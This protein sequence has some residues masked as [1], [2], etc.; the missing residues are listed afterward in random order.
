M[1]SLPSWYREKIEVRDI[2][3][4]QRTG[5]TGEQLA[6]I[7]WMAQGPALGLEIARVG[8]RLSEDE[9]AEILGPVMGGDI[10]DAVALLS[11]EQRELIKSWGWPYPK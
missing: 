10:E 11:Y 2:T 4:Q 3:E 6:H 9:R 7:R 5:L 1:S 8:R